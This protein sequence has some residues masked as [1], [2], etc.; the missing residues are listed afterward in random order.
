MLLRLL[1]RALEKLVREE[2]DELTFSI[3]C[4]RSA[5]NVPVTKTTAN[6]SEVT[7]PPPEAVEIAFAQLVALKVIEEL[8]TA[9]TVQPAGGEVEFEIVVKVQGAVQNVESW[10]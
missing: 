3:D 8:L 9:V 7:A 6:A 2:N 5:V 1:L 10:N 4:V